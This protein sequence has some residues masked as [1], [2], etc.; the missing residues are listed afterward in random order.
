MAN[1]GDTRT[2][3]THEIMTKG[4]FCFDLEDGTEISVSGQRHMLVEIEE[5]YED[6]E[7]YE[8]DRYEID[9]FHLTGYEEGYLYYED[10]ICKLFDVDDYGEWDFNGFSNDWCGI[11]EDD[12]YE[13]CKKKWDNYKSKF[14]RVSSK[15]QFEID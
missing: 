12:D 9:D 2:R 3:L 7:W 15:E 6:G 8:G 5:N 4:N 14:P 10:D 1:N 11:D 13:V